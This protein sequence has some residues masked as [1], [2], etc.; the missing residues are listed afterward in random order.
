MTS[1]GIFRA[2][3]ERGS[4]QVTI[5]DTYFVTLSGELSTVP[6]I[7]LGESIVTLDLNIIRGDG[8]IEPITTDEILVTSNPVATSFNISHEV[9]LNAG[10]IIYPTISSNVLP[11]QPLVEVYNAGML[12]TPYPAV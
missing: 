4:V 3:A 2:A 5:L 12:I 1:G 8:I 7:F 11:G 6:E 10:E 9:V